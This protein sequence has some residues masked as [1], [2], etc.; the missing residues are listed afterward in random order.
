[1]KNSLALYHADKKIPIG[2]PFILRHNGKY[3]LYPSTEMDRDI[4]CFSSDDLVHFQ[5]EGKV[6]NDPVTQGAYAPEVIYAYN[7]FYLCTSPHGNG[8]YIFT[9]KSPLGPFKRMTDNIQNMID[10]SFALDEKHTLHFL[11]ANH[12][13]ISVSK[14]NVDGQASHRQDLNAPLYGWT[15]GPF[16]IYRDGFYYLTY[17]GNHL[18]SKG[19]RVHYSTSK[20]ML[21]DYRPAMNPLLISTTGDYSCLGHS[22][23]VLAPDLDGYY[24]AYHHLF[25]LNPPVNGSKFTRNLGL[26]RIHFNGRFMSL[27][28]TNFEIEN[29][30]MPEVYEDLSLS[31]NHFDATLPLILSKKSTEAKFTAEFNFEKN[32]KLIVGYQDQDNFYSVQCKED[33]LKIVQLSNGKSSIIHQ[34]ALP[35]DFQYFHTVRIIND[36]QAEILIDNVPVCKVKAFNAGKIGYYTRS[37]KKLY[38]TAFSNYANGSSDLQYYNHI[39]GML[40]CK[41]DTCATDFVLDHDEIYYTSLK[42]GDIA[43]FKVHGAARSSYL[44]SCYISCYSHG[45][46]EI[47]TKDQNICVTIEKE[48]EEYSYLLKDFAYLPVNDYDEI[49]IKVL[50]GE[51]S[52]KTFQL[53]IECDDTMNDFKINEQSEFIPTKSENY[54]LTG[55]RATEQ[56]VFFKYNQFK[57]NNFFG[58][59]F[60]SSSF[61]EH[62]G[63][64]DHGFYGYIVGFKG[65]LLVVEHANYGLVRI[66]DKPLPIALHKK[67]QLK[68]TL[69]NSILKVYLDNKF[70]F[71]TTLPYLDSCG[72]NG[73]YQNE[74]ADVVLSSY[75]KV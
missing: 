31:M 21:G 27:T 59:I 20:E 28:P 50:E 52:Y 63:Q 68:A 56:S 24:L 3:Y 26:D 32:V 13:G 67:Y 73:V 48:N 33:N 45:K 2:D 69:L 18:E 10:G 60:H 54:Y 75:Q 12:N 51:L 55:S 41:H 30:M 65:D 44:L 61:S 17:C 53:Q 25:P 34:Q 36:Q 35:V 15:E 64:P 23:T 16:L 57:K 62:G 38:Y 49:T 1:M 47:S 58:L 4:N 39:P 66:Y 46:Y 5:Y 71:E 6:T 43:K 40:D 9:S 7:R 74:Y 11:R 29:P 19:Y 72:F 8:H 14:M 42:Q 70:I 22:S 37:N